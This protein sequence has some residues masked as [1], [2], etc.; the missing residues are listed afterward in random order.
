MRRDYQSD[1][2]TR[3]ENLGTIQLLAADGDFYAAWQNAFTEEHQIDTGMLRKRITIGQPPSILGFQIQ[4]VAFS[5]AGQQLKINKP[6]KFDTEIYLD[7]FLDSKKTEIDAFKS[8]Q[9]KKMAQLRRLEKELE[10]YADTPEQPGILTKLDMM[11]T[12]FKEIEQK[13]KESQAYHI[14]YSKYGEVTVQQLIHMH[15]EARR[16]KV[17]EVKNIKKTI[18]EIREEL[19]DPHRKHREH[20]YY[21][22][23]ILIHEGSSE[24]GHYYTY[25]YDRKRGHWWKMNDHTITIVAKEDEQAMLQEAFG[26]HPGKPTTSACNLF[27]MSPG[28]AGAI[29]EYQP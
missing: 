13:G 24:Q 26:A 7:F 12:G 4:R 5:E 19:Q 29:E 2:E 20:P 22:H 17:E 15:E 23:A 11:I 25:V 1:P 27:Y 18:R 3:V 14:D 16:S 9:D 28:I 21:L 6:F 10:H 8:E